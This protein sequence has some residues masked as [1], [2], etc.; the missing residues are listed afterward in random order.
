[1]T[2]LYPGTSSGVVFQTQYYE[3]IPALT[4]SASTNWLLTKYPGAYLY[5]TLVMSNMFVSD[6][7]FN[8]W[9]GAYNNIVEQ[10]KADSRKQEWS[11]QALRM[12]SDLPV[13]P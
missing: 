6:P 10:I 13:T 8:D 9:V 1:M 4:A 12:E 11:G 2:Y 3:A 7:R 5:G